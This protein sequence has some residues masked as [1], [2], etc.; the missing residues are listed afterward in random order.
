MEELI[1]SNDTPRVGSSNLTREWIGIRKDG[2]SLPL[3]ITLSPIESTGENKLVGLVRDVSERKRAEEL[4]IKA[5]EQAEEGTRAKGHFLA[6]MSHEIRTPMNGIIGMVELL[7]KTRLE[8]KQREYATIVQSSAYALLVLLNDILD[9]SKIEAGRLDLRSIAFSPREVIEEVLG[10]LAPT[11]HQKRIELLCNV[12]ASIPE[13]LRGDPDR[14]R[15][16][17][18]NL[19]GNAVKFTE[20]GEVQIKAELLQ[21]NEKLTLRFEISD[22]GKGISTEEQRRLFQAFSQLDGN[23][24][25]KHGGTG[26]GLVISKLLAEMMGGE[27]GVHSQEG[28][29]STFWFTACFEEAPTPQEDTQFFLKE[30]I[31]AIDDN[32]TNL[33]IL[34]EQLSILGTSCDCAESGPQGLEMMNASLR[35]GRPYSLVLLDFHMPGMDG[36]KVAATIR[37]D[38]RLAKT[39]ILLLS[40]IDPAIVESE[41]IDQYLLKPVTLR[42]LT[43]GLQ[44]AL[45]LA[46]KIEAAPKQEI[47]LPSCRVL[48]IEDNP[49]N[50]KVAQ[51]MLS[52]MGMTVDIAANG[53]LGVEA[54]RSRRYDLV[55]MDCQM[56]VMDGYEATKKIRELEA[57][58]HRTP[59]IALSAHAME[60]A[61][62]KTSA[63]GMD[64]YLVKPLTLAALTAA[65]QK[66]LGAAKIEKSQPIMAIP[67]S[68][69]SH[70]PLLDDAERLAELIECFMEIAPQQKNEV[71]QAPD[72]KSRYQAAHTLK[73]TAL[74][75]GLP[76][77]TNLCGLI[78]K[79]SHTGDI[80]R[81]QALVG[82]LPQTFEETLH[83]VQRLIQSKGG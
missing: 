57:L 53:L 18:L 59:I 24:T 34:R 30:R 11:A 80:A 14:L 36:M 81:T 10:A 74:S 78:E 25:R 54:F 23:D 15:Q 47:I 12:P 22:T 77:L 52:G 38:A 37:Q 43:R 76:R 58:S 60:S 35:A 6:M 75:L 29:G 26:L 49:I 5:K 39:K 19:A 7:L 17:L 56:P 13:S 71:L 33:H 66:W 8:D 64:D 42:A 62:E 40:S 27:I 46:P 82:M 32:K 51:S 31:L 79:A 21:Q 20:T 4:L 73:G 61:K 67:T 3:E 44:S 16:I 55:L 28:K 48:L 2:T 45:Q 9:F 70:A 72:I 65:L 50:Q 69:E 63:A 41:N 1:P 68:H 83:A